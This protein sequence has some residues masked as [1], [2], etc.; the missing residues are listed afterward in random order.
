MPMKPSR[1][2]ADKAQT[3][4]RLHVAPTAVMACDVRGRPI[5]LDLTASALDLP[6]VRPEPL[7]AFEEHETGLNLEQS[8][9]RLRE[10]PRRSTG[11][12]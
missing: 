5:Y 8:L 4:P 6:P 10:R 7:E 3:D 11:R 2:L 9:D 1:T 12:R